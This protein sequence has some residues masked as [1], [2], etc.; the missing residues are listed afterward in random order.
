M[1][2]TSHQFVANAARGLDDGTL[3]A[4]LAR[5]QRDTR[6]SRASIAAL[7]PEF[8]ALCDAAAAIK[9]G[10]LD[11]LDAHLERFER[12]VVESGG[13]VHW[14]RT[15]AEACEAVLAICRD[16]GAT[17]VAKGKSMVSEEIAL[18]D[19][20]AANGVAAVETDLGEYIL[21]LRG[22][23]PSHVVM[24]A[25][26][27]TRAQIAE[28]FR[29]RHDSRDP[30]RP[31]D[32][33]AHL[34]EE[35]RLTL[36][37]AFLGAEIGITGANA[38]IA[39]TGTCLIVTNEGNGDLVHTLPPVHIVLATIE[40][41][42][43]TVADAM[44]LIRVLARSATGQEITCYTS[45]V[46]GP[47]RAD[48]ADGPAGF[49]VILL[50]NGRSDLLAGPFRDVLRCIRCGAC[51]SVCPVYGAIGGHAYGWV[52]GGPIGAVLTPALTGLAGARH[53]PEA[54]PLCGA[55]EAVCPVRIPLPA[56]LRRW[57]EEA[58][59]RRISG[60]AARFGLVLWAFSA[61]RPALYRAVAR[62]AAA[63]L[64]RAGRRSGRF[65]WLPL[66]G[67]W[68]DHRDLPAPEG[69]TFMDRWA[70]ERRASR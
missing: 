23:A 38:L 44:T 39:E 33:A 55:C 43:P 49:H 64:G 35:A 1:Q 25:I 46:T 54:S 21:Q 37:E 50:D 61:R 4:A 31:L 15:A 22:E 10:A 36:R 17:A 28:T 5:L 26:H 69:G 40:K 27:L 19:F 8:D 65:R 48:D 11:N 42:V 58:F 7:L 56:L 2:P 6:E 63:L 67:A 41:I 52:Y 20:L 66:A 34:T 24:P 13:H 59:D 18:N 29:D 51:Q 70:K 57:R 9:A 14:C 32:S 45:F 62:L 53:L 3:R 12:N 60:R 16:H 47:R 30:A 68:T